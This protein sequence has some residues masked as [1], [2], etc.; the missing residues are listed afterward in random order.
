M[1][2]NVVSVGLFAFKGLW[3]TTLLYLLF[4]GLSV[5]GLRAWQHKL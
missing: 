2:V 4:I 3:L 5:V 1:V